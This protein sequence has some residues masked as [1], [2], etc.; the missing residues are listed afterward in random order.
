MIIIYSIIFSVAATS[1]GPERIKMT[2]RSHTHADRGLDPYWTSPEATSAGRWFCKL[3]IECG[4]WWR[5]CAARACA[6]SRIVACVGIASMRGVASV[7]A[8]AQHI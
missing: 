3:D 1:A 2:L 6:R 4:P 7:N 8:D 5:V